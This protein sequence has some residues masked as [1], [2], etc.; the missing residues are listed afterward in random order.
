MKV[1]KKSTVKIALVVLGL[2]QLGWGI[3][4]LWAQDCSGGTNCDSL[5]VTGSYCLTGCSGCCSI[6][7]EVGIHLTQV[8]TTCSMASDGGFPTGSPGIRGSLFDGS[9]LP[10]VS[11]SAPLA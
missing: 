9:G 7:A 2:L 1:L 4:V 5:T 10:G 3:N 6:L 11:V 8:A